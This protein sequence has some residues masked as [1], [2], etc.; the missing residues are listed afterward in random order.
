MNRIWRGVTNRDTF[1]PLLKQR[2]EWRKERNV[3][4]EKPLREDD[5]HPSVGRPRSES[6]KERVG[7]SASNGFKEP[8]C[9]ELKQTIVLSNKLKVSDWCIDI[10]IIQNIADSTCCKHMKYSLRK[11]RVREQEM[12]DKEESIH[13]SWYWQSKYTSNCS[14]QN[15]WL[16]FRSSQSFQYWGCWIE[17]G[18]MM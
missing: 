14:N 7:T 5:I 8:A 11:Q 3:E 2:K 1:Q 9:D 15:E 18:I 4:K 16:Y 10:C 12:K 6:I 13:L 17:H